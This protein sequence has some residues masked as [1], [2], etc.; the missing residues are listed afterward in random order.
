MKSI[1]IGFTIAII[2][3]VVA[4]LLPFNSER[5]V[6]DIRDNLTGNE[7]FISDKELQISAYYNN[8]MELYNPVN[9]HIHEDYIIIRDIAG[10]HP[11]LLLDRELN[12]KSYLGEWGAGPGEIRNPYRIAGFDG[13]NIL[14]HDWDQ[15]RISVFSLE[16]KTFLQTLDVTEKL[17]YAHGA[18][19]CGNMLIT[20]TMFSDTFAYG[21][22]LSNNDLSERNSTVIEFGSQDDLPELKNARN[23]Y[24]LKDGWVAIYENKYIYFIFRSTSLMLAFNCYNGELLFKTMEPS[25]IELPAYNREGFTAAQPPINWFPQA[26]IGIDVDDKYVYV[27]YSGTKLTDQESLTRERDHE[28]NQGRIIHVYD[29]RTGAYKG[30]LKSPVLI[31]DLAVNNNS[32]YAI[33]QYPSI[34]IIKLEKPKL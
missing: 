33:S 31:R 2:A 9:I 17:S 15:K 30:S 3:I 23:N 32:I 13:N 11:L 4:L 21:Y 19:I 8:E 34:S 16:T 20:P 27:I 22:R 14:I 28:L 29:N 1:F 25:Y 10:Q 5:H 7:I 18:Y 6:T 26:N 12:F 24:L